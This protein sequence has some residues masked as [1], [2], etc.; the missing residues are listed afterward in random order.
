MPYPK[1][2]NSI[3]LKNKFYP[4]GLTQ[5]EVWQY[6]KDNKHQILEQTKNRNS[7]IFILLENGDLVVRKKWNHSPINL[8]SSNYDDIISGRSISVHSLINQ[9]DD[10]VIV[11]I[12]GDDFNKV[13]QAT[14]DTYIILT[15]KISFTKSCKIRYTGKTGFHIVCELKRKMNSAV[16]RVVLH[17]ILLNTNLTEKYT[18]KSKRSAGTPNI[19]LFS[20]K[21]GGGFITLGALSE[22]GLKCI[23]VDLGELKNFNEKK[24]RI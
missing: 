4:I 3:I 9:M 11:D 24:A 17:K 14:Y 20:N 16:M 19:D 12:D 21:E 1:N 18:I 22:I 15:T 8:T 13:K 7:M 10:I 23:E 2:P 5:L 6:Y